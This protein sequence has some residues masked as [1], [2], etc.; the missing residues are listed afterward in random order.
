MLSPTLSQRRPY[1]FFR[2]NTTL[3]LALIASVLFGASVLVG[4]TV[5][6][7]TT[8][9]FG[10]SKTSTVPLSSTSARL[11]ERSLRLG[12]ATHPLARLLNPAT[13]FEPIVFTDRPNYF[14]GETALISG[15]GFSP[16]EVVT[17]QVVHVDDTD[18]GGLG[19]E[20]WNVTADSLGNFS[21]TW[22]VDPDDSAGATFR[23]TA[24]GNSSGLFAEYVFT[25]GSANL[26]TC[27]NGPANAPVPCTGA[28]W[29][30]GNLNGSK[31]HYAEGESVP[32]RAVIENL[33]IGNTYTITFEWDTTQ[34][35]KHA[36]DYITTFDE[37]EDTGNNPCTQKQGGS[38]VNI[39]NLIPAVTTPIPVDQNVALGQDGVVSGDDIT[40]I[41][42][43]ITLYNGNALSVVNPGNAYTLDGTY[44]GNSSTSITVQ[45]NATAATAVLAWAGHIAT[46]LDWGLANSAITINGSPYH[47]RL[48]DITCS[49]ANEICNVGQQDHQLSAD[50]VFFP[51]ELT[52]I[53]ETNPDDAQ[54][55]Q[56]N[57]TGTG[58]N[59]GPFS[60]TPPNGTTPAQMIFN[61]T[62][63][64]ARTVTESDPH[65]AFPQFDL[66]GLTCMQTDGG[67]EWDR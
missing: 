16:N 44:A 64:T 3:R 2:L 48:T 56:F 33:I 27:A 15:S 34:S 1:F 20:P 19:H 18:E 51:I 12:P 50:A 24:T 11:A 9:F 41:P 23:L 57:Y 31:S 22:F 30:N 47:M 42:G 37:T 60:L 39:C 46:R 28:N 26:D 38:I 8:A 36:L 43:V 58:S 35:G 54:T 6:A 5:T 63:T 13:A 65:A 4:Y 7:K 17:L 40:P 53:K 32:Y 29:E 59:L 14:P 45:F 55:K 61:L 66:T 49:G 52:I 62:D 21:S 25:D 67:L 10:V